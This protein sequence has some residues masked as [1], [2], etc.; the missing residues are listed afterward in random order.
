ML[1]DP[2]TLGRIMNI[3]G[4]LS[5]NGGLGGILSNGIGEEKETKG[6]GTRS[7]QASV[8]EGALKRRERVKTCDR[9][10]LLEAMRPF[11]SCEKRD[12]LDVVIKIIGLVDAAGGLYGIRK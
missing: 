6:E 9:I 2:E 5:A 8:G 10:R 12:K 1:E 7:E 11:L 4:A 3:A